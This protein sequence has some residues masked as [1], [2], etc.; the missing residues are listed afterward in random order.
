M[1]EQFLY[2]NQTEISQVITVFR[3]LQSI[4]N[5]GLFLDKDNWEIIDLEF[6]ITIIRR[7][8]KQVKS[9][10]D[11]MRHIRQSIVECGCIRYNRE[12]RMNQRQ[13]W[14]YRY[15]QK[16]YPEHYNYFVYGKL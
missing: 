16:I 12:K 7:E 8:F 10:V 14:A 1:N 5:F 4:H 9:L 15:L 6:G 13:S 3:E 11:E 2:R